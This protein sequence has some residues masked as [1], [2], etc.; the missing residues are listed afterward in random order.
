MVFKLIIIIKLSPCLR[1][2]LDCLSLQEKNKNN[3]KKTFIVY[4][5]FVRKRTLFLIQLIYN[6]YNKIHT[7]LRLF[8]IRS[9]AICTN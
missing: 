9:S 7:G 3:I 8:N 6:F 5:F 2:I 1:I 4:H